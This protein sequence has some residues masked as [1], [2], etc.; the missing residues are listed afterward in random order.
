MEFKNWLNPKGNR[1]LKLK[2]NLSKWADHIING[3]RKRLAVSATI[4]PI[5]L[6]FWW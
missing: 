1:E 6:C 3:M 4:Q 2:E 5:W